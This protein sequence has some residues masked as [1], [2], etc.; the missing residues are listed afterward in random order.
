MKFNSQIYLNCYSNLHS[1]HE[2]KQA[3]KTL[4]EI[5]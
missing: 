4:L 3:N 1:S 5:Y 2:S